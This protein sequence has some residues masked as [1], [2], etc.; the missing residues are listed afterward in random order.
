MYFLK[1]NSGESALKKMAYPVVC[2]V[3]L[4]K[5][6]FSGGFMGKTVSESS[7]KTQSSG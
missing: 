3:C 4:L 2:E 1:Q 7:I 5:E 6:I